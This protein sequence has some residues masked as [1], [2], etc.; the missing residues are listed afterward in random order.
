MLKRGNL[1]MSLQD[2]L[3]RLHN[4][5]IT[6]KISDMCSTKNMPPLEAMKALGIEPTPETLEI[7]KPSP[8]TEPRFD[9]DGNTVSVAPQVKT[10]QKNEL[11]SIGFRNYGPN[12]RNRETFRV[13]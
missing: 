3:K 5:R 8:S 9:A 7:V 1:E 11:T 2:M 4:L 13:C 6:A 12:Y 10:C